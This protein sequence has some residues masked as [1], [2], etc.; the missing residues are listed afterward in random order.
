MCHLFQHIV[1]MVD[2]ALA[3]EIHD[4]DGNMIDWSTVTDYLEKDK[5]ISF[6]RSCSTVHSTHVTITFHF[7]LIHENKYLEECTFLMIVPAYLFSL[8]FCNMFL[9]QVVKPDFVYQMLVSA[10][11][12]KNGSADFDTI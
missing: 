9:K 6:A 7:A 4:L 12:R 11:L 8:V 5:F 1:E 3:K 2:P 10:K